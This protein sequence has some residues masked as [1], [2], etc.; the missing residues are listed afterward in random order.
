MPRLHGIVEYLFVTPD[1][2]KPG[3]ERVSPEVAAD[4]HR[5]DSDRLSNM[6]AAIARYREVLAVAAKGNLE[7]VWCT[8]FF[9]V[10]FRHKVTTLEL[11]LAEAIESREAFS[12]R[13]RSS[14]R[15]VCVWRHVSVS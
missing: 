4:V 13:C 9:G 10:A 12:L 6:D 7:R 15:S 5:R 1:D 3:D 2:V 11:V 14:E 8:N